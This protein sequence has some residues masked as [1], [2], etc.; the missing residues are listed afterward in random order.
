MSKKRKIAFEPDDLA[1]L[2]RIVSVDC[3]DYELIDPVALGCNRERLIE[4]QAL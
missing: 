2:K 1:L 3:T 4:L